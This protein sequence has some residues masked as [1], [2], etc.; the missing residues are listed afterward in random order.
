[1]NCVFLCAATHIDTGEVV[2][3]K[4][5]SF[6]FVVLCLVSVFDAF[7]E[8][9]K[10]NLVW[11]KCFDSLW[12]IVLLYR[13]TWLLVYY[14]LIAR[15]LILLIL[16]GNDCFCFICVEISVFQH[17]YWN[18]RKNLVSCFGGWKSFVF[19]LW[20]T[21]HDD[22]VMVLVSVRRICL[23]IISRFLLFI[24]FNSRHVCYLGSRHMT[25]WI[26][27]LACIRV[28]NLSFILLVCGLEIYVDFTC[29]WSPSSLFLKCS[30]LIFCF[31]CA[32]E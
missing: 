5:V 4:I 26:D 15:W 16:A 30:R 31:C 25:A 27:F 14:A 23:G 9:L 2:A 20:G 7:F 12:V 11:I 1:M 18:L 17:V 22:C 13:C 24:V 32:G 10:W 3:V 19:S 29:M 28:W 8:K 6:E 21:Y